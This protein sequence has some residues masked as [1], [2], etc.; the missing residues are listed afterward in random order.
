MAFTERDKAAARV[1]VSIFETSKKHGDPAALAVLDDGAGISF[2]IHQATHKSGSL[3]KVVEHYVEIDGI[4]ADDLKGFL[5]AMRNIQRPAIFQ[6]ANSITL[7]NLLI[8]AGTNDPL[9]RK[10]QEEVVDTNYM[11]PAIQFA[12]ENGLTHPL[13]LAICYDSM[14]QGGLRK[15]WAR[16]ALPL[17]TPA[18]EERLKAYCIERARWLKSRNSRDVRNSAYRPQN[19]LALIEANNWQLHTPFSVR[20]IQVNEDDLTNQIVPATVTNG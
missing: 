20:K 16:L 19:L 1:I 11:L 13:A 18:Q 3:A 4:L 14:I 17:L 9:M 15:V 8:E 6:M 7:R 12:E 5:V 2:G 10:A